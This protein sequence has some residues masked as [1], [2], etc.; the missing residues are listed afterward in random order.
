MTP[1]DVVKHFGGIVA[2]A[3]A[4]GV[5]RQAIYMW[6]KRRRIPAQRAYQVQVV[7]GGALKASG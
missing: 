6:L 2:A 1:R 5:T 4:L 3:D 7:T